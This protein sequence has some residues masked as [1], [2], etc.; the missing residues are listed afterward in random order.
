[1]LIHSVSHLSPNS[2]DIACWVA[3]VNAALCLGTKAHKGTYEIF[4]FL[5]WISNIEFRTC[6]AFTVPL[7]AAAHSR[8]TNCE[9]TVII[10]ASLKT[11][12]KKSL[13][14]YK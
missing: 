11:F 13:F 3:E 10:T 9:V 4:N 14:L 5:D 6:L 2:G 8:Y 1:M 7:C 12:R